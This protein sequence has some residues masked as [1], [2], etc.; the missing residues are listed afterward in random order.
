MSKI[1]QRFLAKQI[2]RKACSAMRMV[3]GWCCVQEHIEELLLSFA[4]SRNLSSAAVL[5]KVLD[6][7]VAVDVEY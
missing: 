7:V 3:L 5:Q 1:S 4:G 6:H 2:R